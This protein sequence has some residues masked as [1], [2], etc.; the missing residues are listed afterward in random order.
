MRPADAD[1]TDCRRAGCLEVHADP[2]EGPI[3][4]VDVAEDLPDALAAFQ[5]RRAD[6]VLWT[7]SRAV[8]AQM[9]RRIVA[10]PTPSNK[11]Q[12]SRS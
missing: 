9:E 8:V 11:T 5:Q 3:I 12:P 4:P 6:L 2:W 7:V 10:M 1:G